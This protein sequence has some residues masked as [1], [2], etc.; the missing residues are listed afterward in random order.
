[1]EPNRKQSCPLCR[2]AM[3]WSGNHWVC[4]NVK[5]HGKAAEAEPGTVIPFRKREKHG[6]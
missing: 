1:M 3:N 6:R 4:V 5:A 2:K